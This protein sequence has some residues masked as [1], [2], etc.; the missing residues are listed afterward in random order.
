ME[1]L[2]SHEAVVTALI[3]ILVALAGVLVA[4]MR[5]VGDALIAYIRERAGLTVEERR[6]EV[7]LDV[8]SAVEQIANGLSGEAKRGL[9]LQIAQEHYGTTLAVEDVEAALKRAQ[10]WWAGSEPLLSLH[11]EGTD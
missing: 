9:A 10:G 3:A 7:A 6:R 1:Q 2:L 4:V 5:A 8:V 11:G